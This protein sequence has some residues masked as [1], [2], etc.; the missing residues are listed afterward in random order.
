VL[1]A[2]STVFSAGLDLLEM[3]RPKQDRAV[4]FWTTLQDVWLKL[5]G[6]SY[7]T[8]AAIN[9]SSVWMQGL[10][11]VM[12]LILTAQNEISNT[13]FKS[14][15]YFNLPANECAVIKILSLKWRVCQLWLV[16]TAD[17]PRLRVCAS[18]F[19]LLSEKLLR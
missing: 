6:S 8:V 4:A 7:P 1:Q 11:S 17:P 5:F 2:A 3:H 10:F 9:V 15:G 19:C 18:W 13:F 16:C 12:Y 14:P